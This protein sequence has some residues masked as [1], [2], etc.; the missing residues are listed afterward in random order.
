MARSLLNFPKAQTAVESTAQFYAQQTKQSFDVNGNGNS[1]YHI[2]PF[3]DHNG[4]NSSN[5]LTILTDSPLI[6]FKYSFLQSQENTWTAIKYL[7]Q[8]RFNNNASDYNVM[9]TG[10]NAY[11]SGHSTAGNMSFAQRLIDPAHSNF[12][13]QSLVAGSTV[14]TSLYYRRQDGGG[15]RFLNHHTVNN[16]T[17]QFAKSFGGFQVMV[18][19][20]P[21]ASVQ[22]ARSWDDSVVVN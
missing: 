16:T 8:V 7:L 14:K 17:N 12:G 1:Q 9:T 20:I 19:E 22:M 11:I 18:E 13:S 3:T 4:S 21:R 2:S 10:S 15:A 6:L 5:S